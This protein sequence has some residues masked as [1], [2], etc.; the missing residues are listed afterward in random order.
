MQKP[1][2]NILLTLCICI[3]LPPGVAA[4]AGSYTWSGTGTWTTAGNWASTPPVGGPG[5][6]DT[7]TIHSGTLYL[8]SLADY[9][10]GARTLHKLESHIELYGGTLT[11]TASDHGVVIGTQA[12]THQ[13]NQY[14]GAINV[15]YLVLGSDRQAPQTAIQSHHVMKGGSLTT[16]SLVIGEG[17]QNGNQTTSINPTVIASLETRGNTSVTINKNAGDRGLIIGHFAQSGSLAMLGNSTLTTNGD[18]YVAYM[19]NS[20]NI[21]GLINCLGSVVITNNAKMEL[22]GGAS[23]RLGYSEVNTL[24]TYWDYCNTGSV[25]VSGQGKLLVSGEVTSYNSNARINIYGSKAQVDFGS[26]TKQREISTRTGWINSM[27]DGDGLTTIKVTGKADISEGIAISI[28]GFV[29]LKTPQITVIEALDFIGMNDL[30]HLPESYVSYRYVTDNTPFGFSRS[31]ETV[32]G[33][34]VIKLTVA[35]DDSNYVWDMSLDGFHTISTLSDNTKKS[36]IH[37]YGSS[38]ATPDLYLK[39]S[40]T[41]GSVAV[42]DTLLAFLNST[43]YVDTG[44]RFTKIDDE[45]VRLSGNYLNEY[46]EA[47]FGWDFTTFEPCNCCGLALMG[48]GL[49]DATS[50]PEPSTWLM[51]LT[52]GATIFGMRCLR[53][54]KRKV[55]M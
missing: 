7:A 26:L 10:L 32:N 2:L 1:C 16:S 55:A 39:F 19:D 22:T 9:T 41:D 6:G 45:N 11:T 27:L 49:L 37:V 42:T 8:D 17:S 21:L 31:Q 46:N 35:T 48:I 20:A 40:T 3:C 34:E 38:S 28:P 51:L 47:W 29:A 44:L 4:Q 54:R 30:T 43:A 50:V 13:I 53:S 24:S 25:T 52:G 12:G 15:P 33:R 23:L 5:L 14:G 36:A 18:V